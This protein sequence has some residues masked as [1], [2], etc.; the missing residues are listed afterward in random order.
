MIEIT[1]NGK[2]SRTDFGLGIE[3]FAIHA[4]SKKKIK[5]SVP[6]MNSVYDFSTIGSN[7]ENVY[8][9]RTIDVNL[10]VPEKNRSKLY[11]KYA[12]VMDWLLE[13][14]QSEL[15]F[16]DMCDIYFLAEVEDAPSWEEFARRLG[17]MT[18]VFIAEPFRYGINLE[19]SDIWDTFNFET[20]YAWP[21]EFDVNGDTMITIY[22]PGRPIIPTI[23]VD[24]NMACMNNNNAIALVAGDNI[25]RSFK[26]ANGRN[27]IEVIGNGHIKFIFRK[28]II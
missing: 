22:N 7:G 17:Y 9:Q 4:P 6:F 2:N 8:T 26:L 28:E 18:I 23:H 20:D 21:T 27:D 16:N 24:A 1:Y 14:G 19:G 25:D 13:A 5:E 11:V 15:V 10:Y 12:Q 3:S